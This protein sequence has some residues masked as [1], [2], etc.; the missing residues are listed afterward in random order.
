MAQKY[1]VAFG[2]YGIIGDEKELV[3]I[4]K[5]GGPYINRYDLPGGSLE[6]GE[7]LQ[8]AIV[9]EI[10]EETGLKVTQFNQLG[11]TSFRYPWD[12]QQWHFNQHI[13]VFYDIQEF[14]GDLQGP[15]DAIFR[16]G[17]ARRAK[18]PA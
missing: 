1:H 5:T 2:V 12:Y 7:P 14:S 16:T 13:G 9:R 8:E 3:V 11:T 6:D 18:S 15:G 10:G 4:R 17:F